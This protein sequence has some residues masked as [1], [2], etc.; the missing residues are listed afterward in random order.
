MPGT[1]PTVDRRRLRGE[2]R[3]LRE[4]RQLSLEVV[5]KRMDWSI[6]KLIRIEN[7]R[8]GVASNDLRSLLDLYGVNDPDQVDG[9]LELAR[10]TRRRSWWSAYR[11]SISPAYSEFIGYESDA[12]RVWHYNPLLVPGL[13]QTK[14]YATAVVTGFATDGSK[15]EDVE[16]RVE[17]RMKRQEDVLDRSEPTEVFAIIDEAVLQRPIG[18]A[19]VMFEQLDRLVEMNRRPKLSVIVIPFSAGFH[20]GLTGSFSILEFEGPDDSDIVFLENGAT[21]V[22]L[23]DKPADIAAFREYVSRLLKVGLAGSEADGFIR[24]AQ[25]R[26]SPGR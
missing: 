19:T 21:D 16:A 2:L 1:G 7:G 6:S 22:I 23:K 12:S 4:E 20:P 11:V 15:P 14:Q 18:S 17:I 24:E 3:R 9:M 13:F 10:S 5:T 8:V 25:K 26:F